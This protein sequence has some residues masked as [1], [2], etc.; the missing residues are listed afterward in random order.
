MFIADAARSSS[1]TDNRPDR[2][3]IR[4]RRAATIGFDAVTQPNNPQTTRELIAQTVNSLRAVHADLAK[5]NE[6]EDGLAVL[7]KTA[8]GTA[9]LHDLRLEIDRLHKLLPFKS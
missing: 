1:G 3:G 7:A 6:T 4:R 5:L 2:P 9:L 8:S